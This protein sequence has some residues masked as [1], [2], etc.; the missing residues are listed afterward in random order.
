MS[1]CSD[2]SVNVGAVDWSIERLSLGSLVGLIEGL[3]VRSLVG[4]MVG[5]NVRSFEG[6]NCW[7]ICSGHRRIC[8]RE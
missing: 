6:V 4:S 8:P 7:F 3:T 5:F 2:R 1:W